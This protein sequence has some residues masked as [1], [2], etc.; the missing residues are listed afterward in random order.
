MKKRLVTVRSAMSVPLLGVILLLFISETFQNAAY[1]FHR[2]DQLCEESGR[3]VRVALGD[4]VHVYTYNSTISRSS[5]IKCHLELAVTNSLWGFSVYIQ[6][7]SLGEGGPGAECDND[8]YLQFGRD[9]LFVTTHLSNKLCYNKTVINNRQYVEIEDT[10]M[11]VWLVATKK[12]NIRE[13]QSLVMVVTP[14]QK[15]CRAGRGVH[16]CQ[17][18]QYCISS[19]LRCDG[20]VNCFNTDRTRSD[21]TDCVTPPPEMGR[22][23]AWSQTDTSDLIL[24]GLLVL[25]VVVVVSVLGY[26]VTRQRFVSLHHDQSQP[27]RTQ[28][29]L[30]SSS[31]VSLA[32]EPP[33]CPPPPYTIDHVPHY[34]QHHLP[35]K[36]QLH[37]P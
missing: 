34:T 37:S 1:T 36:H 16:L 18:G 8:N 14:V 21:E 22:K 28:E 4:S 7:I 9:I 24:Y 23:S 19:N 26:K 3:K 15:E 30:L 17:R 5:H 29:D 31:L 11:D 32:P 10:E 25:L 27:V 13:E 33:S 6:E 12:K 2:L 20:R 35:V